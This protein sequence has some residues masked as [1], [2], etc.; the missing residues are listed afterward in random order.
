[1]ILPLKT[2]IF[3]SFLSKFMK[4]LPFSSLILAKNL[5]NFGNDLGFRI[6]SRD[7]IDRLFKEFN[8][9]LALS[10]ANISG[11]DTIC[12]INDLQKKFSNLD[13]NILAIDAGDIS[14]KLAS[15]IVRIDNKNLEI[16]REGAINLNEINKI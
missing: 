11:E 5:N 7:F 2:Y 1:M 15:T 3:R 9:N 10:S 13:L 6:I 16:L 12:N 4:L 8:G 14:G